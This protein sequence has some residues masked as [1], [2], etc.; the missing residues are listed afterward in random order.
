MGREELII[1]ERLKKL[2]DLKSNGV[3]PYPQIF[4]VTD[5]SQDLQEGHKSLKNGGKSKK[6]VVVA[7][8]HK[9]CKR[10]ISLLKMGG[11]PKRK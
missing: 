4:E 7:T 1:Q 11:N 8:I 10:A 6:K 9:I 3:N 5:Y 2:H